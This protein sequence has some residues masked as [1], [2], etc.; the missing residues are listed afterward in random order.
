MT[1]VLE[2]HGRAARER[3]APS[4]TTG[5]ARSWTRCAARM[6]ALT[7]TAA[8]SRSRF[9]GEFLGNEIIKFRFF[10]F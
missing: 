4:V 6:A 8:C 2:Y 10:L 5:V 9:A 3:R 7:S 1:Q